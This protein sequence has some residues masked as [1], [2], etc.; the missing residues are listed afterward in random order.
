[1]SGSAVQWRLALRVGYAALSFLGL[2]D[3]VP[4]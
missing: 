4:R 1:V 3:S 2:C